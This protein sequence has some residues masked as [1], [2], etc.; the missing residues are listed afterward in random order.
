MRTFKIIVITAL[1][2]VGAGLILAYISGYI[3]SNL[4]PSEEEFD[5][6]YNDDPIAEDLDDLYSK[7]L[8]QYQG[9]VK[10]LGVS[11][12]GEGTHRLE[13]ED[14]LVVILESEKINLPDF[15][16]KEV[17]VRGFVRDTS[18]G[19]QKIMD[20]DFIE[21]VEEA[22]VSMFNEIGY[23]FSF[24]YPADWE[25]KKEADKVTFFE[26]LGDKEENIMLVFQEEEV[27][28]SLEEWLADRDQNLFFDEESIKVGQLTGVRRTVK[29]GDQEIVKTYVKGG[30][31][32]YELRLV[33]QQEVERNQYFSIV[34]FFQ[35]NFVDEEAIEDADT[36]TELIEDET[37]PQEGDENLEESNE[38][39]SEIE[40]NTEDDDTEIT[41]ET[42]ENKEDPDSIEED[43][44]NTENEEKSFTELTPLS[45]ADVDHILEK[46]FS[47]FEGRTLSFDYPKVW[48][49]SYLGDGKYGFTDDGTYKDSEEEINEVNSR[50]LIIAGSVDLSC[51]YK[52]S[53]SIDSTDY[54]VCTRE[55]GLSEIA[56]KISS[57]IS[58][59][60]G[61]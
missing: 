18:E 57:S 34:D 52:K 56:D 19:G 9:S 8:K 4:G 60:T 21:I 55:P 29:N 14:Q 35:T 16:E 42:D 41:E 53:T 58:K 39:P 3:P 59:E 23:E 43:S 20:V 1:L 30:N 33:S 22:G 38:E 6:L 17:K 40:E 7:Q 44:S 28:K 25:L 54:T 5:E 49:F 10:P 50:L 12:Y 11:I 26:K 48:Y 27:E 13:E 2:L 46:G 61:E 15:E 47:P 51:T 24:S 36:D 31:N 37:D 45:Q 32:A